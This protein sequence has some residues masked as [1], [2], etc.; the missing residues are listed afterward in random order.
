MTDV[1]TTLL[2][3]HAWDGRTNDRGVA[4]I[5]FCEGWPKGG[6][7]YVCPAGYWT[8]GYGSLRG[9]D[10][11]RVTL[12]TSPINKQQ[13]QTLLRRDLSVAEKAVH[14]LVGPKLTSNQFSAC[15]SL[16]FNIGSGNFRASQIRQR[17]LREDHD[18]AADIWWQWR[19]GGPARRIL[20]GL[21]KRREMERELF[22]AD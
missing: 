22:E 18:G 6:K 3:A 8:Q 2:E 11:N 5:K 16:V 21:V 4:I 17:L 15:V 10:G 7:P 19:R 13:G 12:D 20:P 9:L 14:V 1:P